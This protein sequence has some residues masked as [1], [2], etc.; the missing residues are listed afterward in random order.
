MLCVEESLWLS[1]DRESNTLLTFKL[2]LAADV[3][4]RKVANIRCN[5]QVRSAD[6]SNIC[7]ASASEL[8]VMRAFRVNPNKRVRHIS[9]VAAECILWS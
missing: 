4:R 3:Q 2:L 1:S 5:M 7:P 6:E 8:R 9:D